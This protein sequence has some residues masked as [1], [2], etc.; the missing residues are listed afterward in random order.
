MIDLRNLSVG[1]NK[2]KYEAIP[3][4]S[5]QQAVKE[6]CPELFEFEAVSIGNKDGQFCLVPLDESSEANALLIVN[7]L[8]L[9]H[10]CAT[11]TFSQGSGRSPEAF[12]EMCSKVELPDDVLDSFKPS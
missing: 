11:A 8:K 9:L 6:E 1:P 7:A 10:V 4:N 2:A 3:G 5:G 12:I